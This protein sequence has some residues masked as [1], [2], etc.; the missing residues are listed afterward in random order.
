[1]KEIPK[2][3]I[4]L[5]LNYQ[6]IY[7]VKS[8]HYITKESINQNRKPKKKIFFFWDLAWA[9]ISSLSENPSRLSEIG[10]ESKGHFRL[11]D[12][13]L[14][15]AKIFLV[16]AKHLS[17]G[18]NWTREHLSGFQVTS[19]RRDCLAWAKNA[20]K[21]A[22]STTSE[23]P[24]MPQMTKLGENQ[25]HIHDE[26]SILAHIIYSTD[27]HVINFHTTISYMQHSIQH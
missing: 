13:T 2:L 1:M 7:L 15:W 17:P 9:K 22:V 8:I 6:S 5:N 27:Q 12:H 19:P 3:S 4:Q 23:L 26:W 20:E 16:R 10:P 14:A 21:P 25:A 24:C 18:R 11:G